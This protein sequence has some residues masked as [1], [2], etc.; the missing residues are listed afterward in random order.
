[1]FPVAQCQE[2]FLVVAPRIVTR[3]NE[4]EAI[5]PGVGAAMQIAHGHGVRVVPAGAGGARRKAVAAAGPGRDD[6]CAFL[7]GPVKL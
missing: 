6:R 1:M 5:L 2:N 7:F 3:I 4:D